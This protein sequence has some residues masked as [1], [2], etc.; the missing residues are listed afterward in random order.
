M[1]IAIKAGHWV[2]M[3]GTRGVL[4]ATRYEVVSVG[5]MP[6]ACTIRAAGRSNNPILPASISRLAPA[7]PQSPAI[8]FRQPVK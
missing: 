3:K 5:P 7:D 8:R 6:D 4:G 2:R 1:E